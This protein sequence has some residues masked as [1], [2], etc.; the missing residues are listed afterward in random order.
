M[1]HNALQNDEPKILSWWVAFLPLLLMILLVTFQ[2]FVLQTSLE[3]N[4]DLVTVLKR[5]MWRIIALSAAITLIVLTFTLGFRW[6]RARNKNNDS[7]TFERQ[8]PIV[9]T[10]EAIAKAPAQPNIKRKRPITRPVRSA[11]PVSD[12]TS[13]TSSTK[14]ST[15]ASE[16]SVSPSVVSATSDIV[17]PTF[18][19]PT[20]MVR[21][22]VLD[23]ADDK[24]QPNRVRFEDNF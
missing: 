18:T 9:A 16:R 8:L 15:V 22:R 14:S 7:N 1:Q 17:S 20:P 23:W 12:T 6:Y 19:R 24:P 13:S 5:R 11:S 3:S 10:T 4:A 2:V 21:P